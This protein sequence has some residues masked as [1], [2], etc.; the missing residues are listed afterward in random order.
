[1]Y[2]TPGSH[3][4]MT[5]DSVISADG[6]ESLVTK[7]DN[8]FCFCRFKAFIGSSATTWYSENVGG[9]HEHPSCLEVDPSTIQG[10]ETY[11]KD[12]RCVCAIIRDSCFQYVDMTEEGDLV[13]VSKAENCQHRIYELKRIE[14]F[15]VKLGKADDKLVDICTAEKT[16]SAKES[17]HFTFKGK[18][19]N[20]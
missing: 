6:V 1:M 3:R 2:V 17:S 11:S 10:F 8:H 20:H 18:K 19:C 12:F 5:N 9:R 16:S 4:I 15:K 13:K 7:T 14:H